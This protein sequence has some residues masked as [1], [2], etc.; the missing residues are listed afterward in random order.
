MSGVSS[1][2]QGCRRN[3]ESIQNRL[4]GLGSRPG[5]RPGVVTAMMMVM[6]M[7]PPF[8]CLCLTNLEWLYMTMAMASLLGFLPFRL[9][10]LLFLYGVVLLVKRNRRYG[11]IGLRRQ[12][13]H[14]RPSG[15][16][17]RRLRVGLCNQVLPIMEWLKA[18]FRNDIQFS[19]R[20]GPR[21]PNHLSVL[22][23]SRVFVPRQH[24]LL[25]IPLI[26]VHGNIRFI[27]RC[28]FSSNLWDRQTQGS[29]NGDF[30]LQLNAV[31][32]RFEPKILNWNVPSVAAS[33]FRS[34]PCLPFACTT[35]HLLHSRFAITQY[36]YSLCRAFP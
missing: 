11:Q 29:A 35:W 34:T 27:Q 13:N 19:N 6:T 7:V 1:R 24:G 9:F 30:V 33:P 36:L 2:E 5:T 25:V 3:S 23:F 10:L 16:W 18:H 31:S 28:R 8:L 14:I 26:R 32:R 4:H 17:L 21:T 15:S 12:H 22:R 20:S